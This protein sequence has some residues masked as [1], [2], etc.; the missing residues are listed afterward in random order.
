MKDNSI[1]RC[2]NS[3]FIDNNKNILSKSSNISIDSNWW[4]KLDREFSLNQYGI[5]G[6]SSINRILDQPFP[7]GTSFAI[8]AIFDIY[9]FMN[10]KGGSR[11]MYCDNVLKKDAYYKGGYTWLIKYYES[12]FQ[13]KKVEKILKEAK[14]NI[15]DF[16]ME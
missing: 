3:N 10:A 5:F 13:P 7:K 16:E 2:L 11:R 8:T 12:I 6:N 4:G 1:L 9:N 15:P 14:R